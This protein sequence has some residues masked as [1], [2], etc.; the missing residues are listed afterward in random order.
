MTVVHRKRLK[1]A[2]LRHEGAPHTF[3]GRA[4]VG[5][6][7]GPPFRARG[8]VEDVESIRSSMRE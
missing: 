5:V 2:G 7:G 8:T 1:L 6:G 3:F 4:G